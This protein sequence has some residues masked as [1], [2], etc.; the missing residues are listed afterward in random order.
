MIYKYKVNVIILKNSFVWR[1]VLRI[2]SGKRRGYKLK[3][4]EGLSTRPTTDRVKESV[5]NIIQSHLP[6]GFVLDMFAGSGAMGIE[7]LS[8]GA[9]GA[10]FIEQ[11]PLSYKIVESNLIGSGLIYGAAL[12]KTDAYPLIKRLANGTVTAVTAGGTRF[13]TNRGFD[14]IFLDPPYNKGHVT[15]ALGEIGRLGLLNDNGVIVAETE[16]GGEEISRCGFNIIRE[17]RYGK[18]II[19]VMQR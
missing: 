7:A 11:N 17:A 18:T 19:T 9:E 13:D 3:A 2:I 4:P 14:I 15:K 6:C 5:F 10:V 8:R 12:F 16:V 1:L